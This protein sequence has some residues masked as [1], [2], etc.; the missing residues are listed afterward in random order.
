MIGPDAFVTVVAAAV[1]GAAVARILLRLRLAAPPVVLMRVNV[2]GRHVPAI[3]GSPMVFGGMC[4][5]FFVVAV[6]STGW[7]PGRIGSIGLAV[8]LLIVVMYVAGSVDDRRGDEP[9]RGFG[10]HLG[11]A[12]RGRLTGG[13]VKMLVGA[14]AGVAAGSLVADGWRPVLEIAAIVALSANLVNLLDRAPGRAGKVSVLLAIPPV[15]LAPDDWTVAAAGLLGS[16]AAVL[17]S[18]LGEKAMLGDAGANPLGAVLGL[19]LALAMG[20]PARVATVVLLLAL[21]AASERWS[22]S[23]VIESTPALAA[24]DRLGRHPPD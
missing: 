4:G 20:E 5:M 13:V 6:G 9:A 21:N 8:G 3:L 17:P 12:R 18:D 19:G 10:G 16:L 15:L 11:A 22:F 1:I 2:S 14:V 23:K 7:E 24:F